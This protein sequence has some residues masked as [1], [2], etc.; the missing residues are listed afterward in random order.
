[1]R[2]TQ[3]MIRNEYFVSDP[4]GPAATRAAANISGNRAVAGWR[5]AVADE[6]EGGA[7]AAATRIATTASTATASARSTPC[8][9][10]SVR[11]VASAASTVKDRSIASV[12]RPIG[13]KLP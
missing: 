7:S 5:R 10:L 11:P 2:I 8:T 1:M 13:R 3:P 4:A 12:N 9:A 6:A